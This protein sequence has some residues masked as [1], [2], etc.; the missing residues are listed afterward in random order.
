MFRIQSKIRPVSD[1]VGEQPERHEEGVEKYI[2]E[3][4]LPTSRS[5]DQSIFPSVKISSCR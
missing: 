1:Q 5:S 2:T 3:S 4:C